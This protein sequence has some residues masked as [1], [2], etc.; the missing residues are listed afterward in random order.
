MK[1]LRIGIGV[2]GIIFLLI[3]VVTTVPAT[4][5]KPLMTSIEKIE[6]LEQE[7]SSITASK[8]TLAAQGII[9]ILIQLVSL[10]INLV[11]EVVKVVQNIMT[12][13][14]IIQ[15][16]IAAVQLLFDM[17]GQLID[18]ITQLFNPEPLIG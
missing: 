13:V 7:L 11:I 6:D 16:L 15:S 8:T 17:I 10:I 12:L 3:S 18:L 14:A 5:S 1:K 9:D 2:F 4:H